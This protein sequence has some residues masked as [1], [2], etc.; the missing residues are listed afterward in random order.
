MTMRWNANFVRGLAESVLDRARLI[1]TS[2]MASVADATPV[3][4]KSEKVKTKAS[5]KTST[6]TASTSSPSGTKKKSTGSSRKPKAPG[7]KPVA[8]RRGRDA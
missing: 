8:R 1:R 6:K 5:L 4:L 7:R 3:N 2:L